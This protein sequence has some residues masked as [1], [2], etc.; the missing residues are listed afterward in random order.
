M[1]CPCCGRTTTYDSGELCSVCYPLYL[2][3]L[4][5]NNFPRPFVDAGIKLS[6]NWW[7]ELKQKEER[8]R[9]LGKTEEEIRAE[10]DVWAQTSA[11]AIVEGIRR[12]N[13]QKATEEARAARIRGT[14]YQ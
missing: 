6:F 11:D 1:L 4:R 10:I 14:K 7:G 9:N 12:T 8:L 2:E 5:A 13:E 3:D